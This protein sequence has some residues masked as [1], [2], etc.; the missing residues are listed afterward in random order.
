[1]KQV[2]SIL[3]LLVFSF[4]VKAADLIVEEFGTAPT[5][6]SINAAIS[7]AVDGDR[8][9]IKNRAGDIP[10]IENF[11]V[12][13]SLTFLSYTNNT[14]FIVQGSITLNLA[15]NREINFV[16]MKNTSGGLN[17]GTG[18]ATSRTMKV[19]IM[20]CWFV[21]GNITLNNAGVDAQIIGNLLESGYIQLHYGN[22]IGNDVTSF[23]DVITMNPTGSFQGD[24]CYIVANKVNSAN[25]SNRGIYVNGSSQAYHVRNNYVQHKGYGIFLNLGNTSSVPNLVWNNTVV[26]QQ[27]SNNTFGIYLQGQSNSVWEVMNNILEESSTG[28]TYGIYQAGAGTSNVYYNFVDNTFDSE[29]VGSFTFTGNNTINQTF[30]INT[31]GTL[32]AGNPGIN[33]GNPAQPYYD[34][35][36]T[37]GDVGAYG[38]SYTLTNFFPQFTGAARV[39]FVKFPFNVRQGSTLSIKAFGYDR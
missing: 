38:G 20:D 28:T 35:D 5:Y 14:Q 36:L 26:N 22:V 16:G 34:L 33:A 2:I 18:T 25:T 29:I 15:T 9:I 13:K 17:L 3:C 11:T 23:T 19:S 37:V 4:S 21:A 24:T 27:Y 39:Y 31:N 12:S 7:A 10:W 1:M 32:P 6:G 30:T 8:I